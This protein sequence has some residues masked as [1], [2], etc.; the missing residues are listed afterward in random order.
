M[1]MPWSI[2]ESGKSA[3]YLQRNFDI[4]RLFVAKRLAEKGFIL[5]PLE[6]AVEREWVRKLLWKALPAREGIVKGAFVY[7]PPNT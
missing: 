2:F 7:V 5:E 1:S 4:V 6:K 3:N